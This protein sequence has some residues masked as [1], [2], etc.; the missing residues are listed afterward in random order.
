MNDVVEALFVAGARCGESKPSLLGPGY[1]RLL[2]VFSI[3]LVTGME[4]GT[5]QQQ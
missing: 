1:T 4:D 3:M 5:A 2:A